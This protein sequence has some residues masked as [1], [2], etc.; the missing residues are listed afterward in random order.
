VCVCV[1]TYKPQFQD[2]FEVS[3]WQLKLEQHKHFN[4]G[5]HG[6]KLEKKRKIILKNK[7]PFHS[8]FFTGFLSCV[9]RATFLPL[10]PHC[11]IRPT[12]KSPTPLNFPYMNQL[13]FGNNCLKSNEFRGYNLIG[14]FF[15]NYI[16]VEGYQSFETSCLR[17]QFESRKEFRYPIPTNW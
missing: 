8:M 15:L 6:S 3:Q 2:E 12:Y 16:I 13:P 14:Y 11:D 5:Q 9:L 4:E 1:L 7:S 17:L 10:P